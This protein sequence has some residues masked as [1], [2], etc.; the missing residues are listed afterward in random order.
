MSTREDL[1]VSP[2]WLAG[3]LDD[4]DMAVVD[5]SWH[6][7]SADRDARADYEAGHIPGAVFIDI[8]TI[9]DTESPLPHM[10]PTPEEFAAAIGGLG[11]DEAQMIVVYDS[12]GL[13]SAPRVRWMFKIMG[14][15]TVR[16]LNGGLPAWRA[17]GNDIESG[18]AHPR[19]RVFRT[20]FD[21]AAVRDLAAIRSHVD[22]RDVQVVD[23]RAPERFA[24]TASEPRPGVSS[25]RIPG[26]FNLPATDLIANGRLKDADRIA[27]LFVQAGIDPAKPI[28]TS[29][30]S[31]VTA[32]IVNLALETIG[33]EK[34]GLYDGSWAEWGG[35]ADTPKHSGSA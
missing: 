1:F 19:P 33:V 27:G 26:S 34:S 23:A 21:A 24:G 8:D 18:T 22:G 31:G 14:A 12:V 16:I 5:G 15:R 6:L 13:Y 17:A 3:H 11:I 28:V 20:D 7:P 29:C 4:P 35:R 25:G 9:A 30:G 2:S 32:A 10:L